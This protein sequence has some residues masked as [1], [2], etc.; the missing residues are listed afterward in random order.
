MNP[1]AYPPGWDETRVRDLIA[2]LESRTEEEWIAADEAM[3]VDGEE[4]TEM[5]VPSRLLPQIRRLRAM[6]SKDVDL[7]PEYEPSELKEGVRGKYLERYRTGTNLALL[8]PDV[9]A[10]FPT[11]EE[12]NQALR[13]LLSD[14][15]G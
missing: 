6:H 15:K 5:T 2:E 4:L 8:A 1:Q 12:V 13:S 3:V 14:R 9:R 7:R 11:D 10:A